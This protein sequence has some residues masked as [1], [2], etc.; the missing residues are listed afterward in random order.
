MSDLIVAGF[1]RDGF[2]ADEVLQTLTKLEQANLIDIRD[3][4]VIFKEESKSQRSSLWYM[5]LP[6]SR[7]P[8]K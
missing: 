8:I 6:L 3:A 4:K 2:V 1:N 7:E 5:R